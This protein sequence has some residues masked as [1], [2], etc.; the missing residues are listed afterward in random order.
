MRQGMIVV[1]QSG[2][3]CIQLFDSSTGR[4]MFQFGGCGSDDLQFQFPW[5]VGVD[6]E[7]RIVVCDEGNDCVKVI[8]VQ[9]E[10]WSIVN[11]KKFGR[12]FKKA[13]FVVM[14]AWNRRREWLDSSSNTN[15]HQQQEEEEEE[16]NSKRMNVFARLPLEM[17]HLIIWFVGA[18][19]W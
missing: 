1:S 7:G 16:E 14:V 5:G 9:R 13:V 15:R 4:F 3:H 10:E 8:C 11:H 6:G 17:I 2:N 12:E 18:A 19:W